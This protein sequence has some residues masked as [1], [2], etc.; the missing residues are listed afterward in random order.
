MNKLSCHCYFYQLLM[1][2]E[3]IHFRNYKN[4]VALRFRVRCVSVTESVVVL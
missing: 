1:R 4:H 2:D 3:F